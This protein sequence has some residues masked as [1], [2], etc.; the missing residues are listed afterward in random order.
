M[1]TSVNDCID[2]LIHQAKSKRPRTKLYHNLVVVSNDH[3]APINQLKSYIPGEEEKSLLPW[4]N[5]IIRALSFTDKPPCLD[6]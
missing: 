3:H 6:C 2:E 1:E 5:W 4:P